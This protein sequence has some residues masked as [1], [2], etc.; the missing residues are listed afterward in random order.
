MYPIDGT[1]AVHAAASSGPDSHA[2]AASHD[3]PAAAIRS[4]CATSSA[5]RSPT[6]TA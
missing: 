4:G 3:M 5:R 1:S 2:D 6:G